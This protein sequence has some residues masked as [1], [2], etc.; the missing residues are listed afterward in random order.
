MRIGDAA[1]DAR[2][3][4]IEQAVRPPDDKP[5]APA[6][7]HLRRDAQFLRDRLVVEAPRTGQHDARPPRQAFQ[8]LRSGSVNT[9]GAFGRPVRMSYL[10][11]QRY[12][13]DQPLVYKTPETRH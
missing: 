6:P 12:D 7:H 10:L 13:L 2:A 11:F 4:F 1:W 9:N 8:R 3:G 5:R